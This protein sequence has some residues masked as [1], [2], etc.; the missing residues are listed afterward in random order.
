MISTN[1]HTRRA[2]V[3][4]MVVTLLAL[5]F[6][7]VT[8][9]LT[10]ARGERKTAEIA[11]RGDD[12]D[13]ALD[14]AR[15]T[16]LTEIQSQLLDG[17]G[18]V[19]GGGKVEDENNP[20]TSRVAH[21]TQE[22]VPG[23][24]GSSF[25]A[26]AEPIWNEA[27][28]ISDGGLAAALPENYAQ[29]LWWPTVSVLDGATRTPMPFALRYLM[30]DYNYANSS[31]VGVDP[32]N[33]PIAK[34]WRRPPTLN[35]QELLGADGSFLSNN[36]RRPFMDADGD[37]V[38]DT[39][40]LL[41][42][43][44]TEVANSFANRSVSVPAYD[45]FNPMYWPWNIPN[46]PVGYP[47]LTQ[48]NQYE[49]SA[50]Y[51]VPLRII[52]HGGMLSL[53]SP[54][55]R[56]PSNGTVYEPV[57]RKQVVDWFDALR[58]PLD[59]RAMVG[60]YPFATQ[61][62]D[63]LFDA[64]AN[65]QVAVE[66]AL[67]RRMLLPPT[68]EQAGRD[69]VREVPQVLA[70]LEGD[71]AGFPNT[72]LPR[73]GA[74]PGQNLAELEYDRIN[75]GAPNQEDLSLDDWSRAAALRTMSMNVGGNDALTASQSYDRRHLLT[76]I[77]NSDEL[78]RKLD[79]DEPEVRST[80][81]LSGTA[82]RLELGTLVGERKFYLGEIS[83]AFEEINASGGLQNGSGRYRY[84]TA[85]G[86]VIV[87]ELARRFYDMLGG[88]EDWGTFAEDPNSNQEDQIVSRRQQALMLAVNAVAFATPRDT[89]T[90][91]RG[92]IELVR[93][94]DDG[95]TPGTPG[96][97]AT[98]IG[99]RPSLVFSEVITGVEEP[100]DDGDPDTDEDPAL[101]IAVELYNPNAPY[102]EPG[103]AFPAGLGAD[104]FALSLE[105]Y[106][107]G[108]NGNPPPT[109]STA[110]HD[111]TRW[112]ALE[113]VGFD[114][115]V[116]GRT[117]ATIAI[118]DTSGAE[119]YDVFD[120]H[121]FLEGIPAKTAA[122]VPQPVGIASDE[123]ITLT[124]WCKTAPLQDGTVGW[125][126]VDEIFL[127]EVPIRA[128]TDGGRRFKAFH[129][130]SS[131][132]RYLGMADMDRNGTFDGAEDIDGVD[133]Y[134]TAP[135][136]NS[137]ARWSILMGHGEPRGD[138]DNDVVLQGSGTD[139]STISAD[140]LDA[141]LNSP[142]F[143]RAGDAGFGENPG[144]PSTPRLVD[145]D[146]TEGDFLYDPTFARFAPATPFISMNAGPVGS[147]SVALHRRLNSLPMFG[148]TSDLRP[149]SYPTVGFML[150]LPRFSHVYR[151]AGPPGPTSIED[152]T[153]PMCELLELAWKAEGSP[154]A[155]NTTGVLP[156]IY[157]IDFG[158]MPTFDNTHDVV[159]N[160][161]FGEVGA[162]PWGQLV[163]DYFT[164]IDPAQDVNADGR[165]DIDPLKVPG[166]INV[167]V[168]AWNVLAELPLMGPA[169]TTAAPNELPLRLEVSSNG[170]TSAYRALPTTAEGPV[171]PSP[172]F[173]DPFV[174][175]V[176]GVATD[177]FPFNGGFPVETRR[178][179]ID[180]PLYQSPASLRLASV[181]HP[182]PDGDFQAGR[183]RLGNWL[184]Q[185]AV[186][187]RDGIQMVRAAPDSS[188]IFTTAGYLA[189]ADSQ[190]RNMVGANVYYGRADSFG[191]LDPATSFVATD[192]Y[193]P[194]GESY[195]IAGV[196]LANYGD[197]RGGTVPP[198]VGPTP[199]DV[200]RG[201]QFGFLSIGEMLNVK[202]FDSTR[203]DNL[204]PWPGATVN[205]TTV[206]R[207]DYL[208]AINLLTM[209]DSQV[210]TTR[211]NTFTI[212]ATVMD[213]EEPE[214]S[215][216]MQAT[217]DR[218]NQLPRLTY[219]RFDPGANVTDPVD[220]QVYAAGTTE[221]RRRPDLPMLPLMIQE[222]G[223]GG[224]APPAYSPVRM[225]NDDA[226]PEVLYE[227]RSS[228]LNARTGD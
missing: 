52:S 178:S 108:I 110:Q 41:T 144:T 93:F 80:L 42:G 103:T 185:S 226:L 196:S 134:Y 169:L 107:I 78:A 38:P 163:F 182:D 195:G 86:D 159:P 64:L 34:P 143:I 66:A 47:A 24:R 7:I 211:S 141:A 54:T 186:A 207:G 33:S 98:Y 124:L 40:L 48:F 116:N 127:K 18:R 170:L 20:T 11:G 224:F 121:Q 57:N 221:F 104:V 102:Y 73:F 55:L 156:G 89:A 133:A 13:A 25:L 137:Y 138:A 184:A 220:D 44:L 31:P 101:S 100:R 140:D 62:Q 70:Q 60:E 29:W 72:L 212:Y 8:G 85:K 187:Y 165:P 77:N 215:V 128:G 157:P 84:N 213:R 10:L 83:K 142:M 97:D 173:W 36:A 151:A 153:L 92:Y 176:T 206:G 146:A 118:K 16:A 150:Y 5:L 217:V 68:A 180:D 190:L 147:T 15:D 210:I 205:S 122:L 90:D 74:N 167:N 148:N 111:A 160:G 109:G 79:P 126:A 6:V 179:L 174:S 17:R 75:I 69:F 28:G 216:R 87:R 208:K 9:F 49:A 2:T 82:P 183:Y 164:T 39:H 168:A 130:D 189:Y 166:R 112:V 227:R 136:A 32:N 191:A 198:P 30:A 21:A 23:Y 149:R 81:G 197:M 145:P 4:L 194:Q 71:Q 202:G 132:T 61:R 88:H 171:D 214:R 63:E 95:G 200:W 35:A 106:A 223:V 152:R 120:T 209:L 51:E 199:V 135:L 219:A 161:Y 113:Y 125:Y 117:Y 204:P 228:Y 45:E 27:L 177:P 114:A 193:R 46:S 175:T 225:F 218:S 56:D 12:I 203:H 139:L 188:M 99:Y 26:A 105:Q 3:L 155:G 172:E 53:Y 181:P 154:G 67:R 96:D 192:R 22:D 59:T 162:V 222:S 19:L 37:G 119:T 115:L 201:D 1:R 43:R 123:D 131:P 58:N 50:K 76:T 94:T 158:F 65:D 91:R 129:R 14:L